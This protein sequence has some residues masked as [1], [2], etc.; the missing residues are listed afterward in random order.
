MEESFKAAFVM[1]LFERTPEAAMRFLPRAT[2]CFPEREAELFLTFDDGPHPAF[3]S[4]LLNLL[5]KHDARASFFLIGEKARAH[6]RL[7]REIVSAGHVIGNHTMQH[8]QLRWQRRSVVCE[9]IQSAQKVLEDCA[10][11]PVRFFRPPY[12]ALSPAILRAAKDHTLRLTMWSLLAGDVWRTNNSSAIAGS[13]MKKCR[14]GDI[15]LLHDG[16]ACGPATIAAVSE[17]IPR[18]KDRGYRF[19]S[20]PDDVSSMRM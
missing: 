2:W 4:S 12:G 13:I 19:R 16:H 17:T 20:L 11:E 6:S 5:A 3:T 15:I 1:A 14:G 9:E 8:R 10:G 18:L 7:A